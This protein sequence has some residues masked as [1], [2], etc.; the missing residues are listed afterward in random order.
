M[1]LSIMYK[2]IKIVKHLRIFWT[3][4]ICTAA[5][6][7]LCTGCKLNY[8]EADITETM[9]E[10]IPNSV[11]DNF[12][13]VVVR[14]GKVSYFFSA[15]HAELFDST[16]TTYF[17]NIGFTE[18]KPS[19]ETGTEGAAE[20]AIHH[21]KTDN[22]IFDGRIILNATSQDF[23]VKSDYLEWNNE[24]KILKSMDDTLVTIEQGDGTR[25]EGRGFIADAQGK[26][27]TF[28]EEASGRY[29]KDEETE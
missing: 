21:S 12:S 29:L 2:I 26:S 14:D 20:R 27:F 15:D 18:Y 8:K 11:L 10:E 4:L 24:E 17:D 19:G 16:G 3:F 9:A 5:G 1:T 22:I 23:V 25:V 7:I 28:L 13:Q 6:F